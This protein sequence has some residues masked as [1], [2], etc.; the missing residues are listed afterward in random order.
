MTLFGSD[1]QLRDR[2]NGLLAS[3]SLEQKIGQMVMAERS[4]C[5]P[6]D[7][8]NFHLGAVLCGSG[9]HPEENTP[10]AWVKM[11][12]AYW[13]AA[14]A[15]GPGHVAIPTLFGVDAIHGHCNV[16]G[17]TVFPH[18]IG[19]GAAADAGLVR[20][21]AQ[22][23]A[24]E[25]LA[26]GIEWT[27]APNLAVARNICW[28]RSY[29]SVG[30][31]VRPVVDFARAAVE[32]LQGDLGENAVLAC[33][34]HWVGDGGNAHGIDHGNNPAELEALR[35]IDMAPYLAALE[36]GVLTIMAS[37][38]SWKGEKC[39]GH[40]FLLTDILKGELQFKGMLISDWEG[41]TYL[42]DDYH[43]AVGQAVNAG[44]DMFMVP[45]SWHRFIESLHQHALNGSV[46]MTR[47]NNAVRRILAVKIAYGLFERPRPAARPWSNHPSFGCAEHR[48]LAREAVRKSLV[49]LQN[50][51]SVLPLDKTARLLVAG[52][53]AHNRGHLCG[54]F[55]IEWQGVSGN[56]QIP[57]ATSIW[58]G[59]QALA[60]NASLSEDPL[61]GDAD[62]QQHDVALVVV[63]EYPYAEGLGDVRLNEQMMVETGSQMSGAM[64][65]REPYGRTLELCQLHPEDLQLIS[66]IAAKGIPVVTVL[67]SGRP[68][69]VNR[70]L[71][72]S[73][74][75]VA[76]WLPGSEGLGVAEVLFGDYDFQGRLPFS[77]P[78]TDADAG[79]QD[80]PGF[81]PLFPYGYGLSYQGMLEENT[82][83][84]GSRL[85]K[86]LRRLALRR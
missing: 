13:A 35:E 21:I 11:N 15:A 43:S 50:R 77:W 54:G 70:E 46:S 6:E 24:R 47:I 31:Q 65:V 75:F 10:A 17:A 48:N 78:R 37:F 63:G 18:N 26:S 61:G 62:P 66:N 45:E 14:M 29:E 58:E 28:G 25:V 4:T 27:F 82:S 49:L 12:D 41:T 22:I 36:A 38:N 64:I 1:A 84:N 68:L 57:G 67:V 42:S 52:K 74:A 80:Q 86:T 20:R 81:T 69:V 79:A 34:K 56:E 60:A 72:K 55:S 39:H 71:E 8:R 23:T 5:S 40:K 30:E 76:A 53:N 51:N 44:I 59:V 32:G 9:S 73:V 83:A 2:V 85:R 3:M 19:L 33:A 16:S 7:V